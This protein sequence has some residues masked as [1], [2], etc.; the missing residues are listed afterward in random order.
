M[1]FEKKYSRFTFVFWK[2]KTNTK[3]CLKVTK[4]LQKHLPEY[5]ISLVNGYSL[6]AN[7]FT[8]NS[9]TEKMTK[10]TLSALLVIFSV[11]DFW[12]KY[13]SLKESPSAKEVQDA[14]ESFCILFVIFR[15]G[16]VLVLFFPKKKTWILSIFFQKSFKR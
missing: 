5:G 15:H 8:Q 1:I 2:K 7:Y 10:R 16:L 4:K 14:E 11:P 9:D 12:V 13:L 6:G 3:P